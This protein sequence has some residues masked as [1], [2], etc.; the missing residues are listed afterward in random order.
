MYAAPEVLL[1][2]APGPYVITAVVVSRT[3][4]VGAGALILEMHLERVSR[5]ELVAVG[6]VG[7][8]HSQ[9]VENVAHQ[10]T[11]ATHVSVSK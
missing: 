7:A 11:G 10:G 1:Q 8:H 2:L 3:G 5:H 6:V 4:D 9:L